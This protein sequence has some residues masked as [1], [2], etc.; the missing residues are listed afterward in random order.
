MYSAPTDL[1]VSILPVYDAPPDVILGE[2]E[3]RAASLLTLSCQV[4]GATGTVSYQWSST[5]TGDCFFPGTM[6]MLIQQ[7]R[8]FPPHSG[9]ILTPCIISSFVPLM[10]VPTH[11]RPLMIVETQ[12]V[13]PGR[14]R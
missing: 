10:L 1:N 4:T 3:Y 5:C 11:V 12:G 7:L 8:T 2:D 6:A 14:S 13:G 9:V